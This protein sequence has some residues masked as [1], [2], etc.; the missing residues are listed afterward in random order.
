MNK[1][2]TIEQK[3]IVIQS[4]AISR[5]I[6]TCSPLARKLIAYCILKIDHYPETTNNPE[7]S[8]LH[9]YRSSFSISELIKKLG[10]SKGANTY[11]QVKRAV[12]ELSTSVIQV[13]NTEEKYKAFTW[14]SSASY[15]KEK[16]L[17]ELE[18]NQQIGFAIMEWK[19]TKQ[20]SALNIKTIGEL[21][22]FYALRFFEIACSWYNTKS[23]Y[24]NQKNTWT[25][26]LT[27]DA[28]KTMFKIDKDAYKDRMNNF[29]TK[30]IKNPLE[31]LNSVNK[32]FQ[33]SYKKVVENRQTVGFDFTCV[34]TDLLKIA[35]TDTD[36][37]KAE[38]EQINREA[39]EIEYYKNKYPEEWAAA[40][41]IVKGQLELP[42]DFGNLND[43][44]ILEKLKTQGL[45]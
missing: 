39:K 37:E 7:V 4:N 36:D 38:K 8:I 45:E 32:D 26:S 25:F 11:K 17:I 41:K 42:F 13:E 10:I 15:D 44:R 5:G 19:E 34:Q 1:L 29:I 16:D 20:F 14:F 30:V 40:E 28:I 43:F 12:E 18:F 31:E 23:R 35:S 22:S 6:Y 24:G 33:I 3:E 21:Q 2:S 9:H 27:V